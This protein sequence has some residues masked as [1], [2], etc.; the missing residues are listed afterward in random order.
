MRKDVKVLENQIGGQIMKCRCCGKPAVSIILSIPL[1]LECLIEARD[2]TQ[3]ILEAIE[4]AD[5]DSDQKFIEDFEK[6]LFSKKG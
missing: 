2:Y 6:K 1:C 3:K 4:K 5:H